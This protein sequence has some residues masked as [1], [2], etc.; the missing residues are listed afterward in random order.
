MLV[1]QV[2]DAGYF[3]LQLLLGILA[4]VQQALLAPLTILSQHMCV[5]L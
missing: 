1:K 5:V 2:A 4:T 3:Q